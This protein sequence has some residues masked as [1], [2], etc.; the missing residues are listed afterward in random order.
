MGGKHAWP[1]IRSVLQPRDDLGQTQM[2]ERGRTRCTPQS[3]SGRQTWS[4]AAVK[5][6]IPKEPLD[7]V[8]SNIFVNLIVAV[9]ETF[10]CRFGWRRD[11]NHYHDFN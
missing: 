3:D 7:I 6:P 10:R 1:K 11:T 9:A 4:G 5:P 2:K 8:Q